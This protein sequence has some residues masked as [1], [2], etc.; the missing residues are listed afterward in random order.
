MGARSGLVARHGSTSSGVPISV[1]SIV[2][3]EELRIFV[4]YCCQPPA[5][6]FTATYHLVVISALLEWILRK[7]GKGKKIVEVS[8]LLSPQLSK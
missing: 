2:T 7:G 5:F 4:A 1:A 6:A 3:L 8:S